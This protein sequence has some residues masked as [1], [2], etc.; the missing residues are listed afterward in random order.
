VALASGEKWTYVIG[1]LD[2][3]AHVEELV[4]SANSFAQS[5]NGIVPWKDRPDSFK[6]GVVSRTPPIGFSSPE[7]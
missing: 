6:K 2:A 1:D 7:K 3:N 5:E 4:A